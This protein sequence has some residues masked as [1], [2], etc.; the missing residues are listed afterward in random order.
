MTKDE[1]LNNLYE[2]VSRGNF[3]LTTKQ[4]NDIGLN[5]RDIK[6]LVGN[7]TLTF[8]K[9]GYYSFSNVDLLY[10]FGTQ[11][12]NNNNLELAKFFWE[13]C[14][15]L[16]KYF[17]SAYLRLLSIYISEKDYENSFKCLKKLDINKQYQSDNNFYWYLL[18]YITEVPDE[19]KEQIKNFDTGDIKTS[20][21]K[22]K[23]IDI[24][25]ENKIRAN[26]FSG[27]LPYALNQL[28]DYY[29]SKEKLYI[30][31]II[32]K[33]L[34][35]QAVD[36]TNI[37]YDEFIMF[38]SNKKYN[39]IYEQ[40]LNFGAQRN[41]ST[42][43]LCIIKLIEC[44]SGLLENKSYLKQTCFITESV[45][46]A[47]NNHNYK[48]AYELNEKH[49]LE[50]GE[51]LKAKLLSGLLKELI[52]LSN[53]FVTYQDDN[54]FVEKQYNFIK[55]QGV[56]LLDSM[57]DERI[58]NIIKVVK[59][60]PNLDCWVIND[61]YNNRLVLRYINN[62]EKINIK[63][64]METADEYYRLEEY[65]SCIPLYKKLLTVGEPPVKIYSR[66]GFAHWKLKKNKLASDYFI[67]ANHIAQEK[68]ID[69]DYI[70]II[71]RLTRYIVS[72]SSKP[73]F[74][75][76]ENIS[77]IYEEDENYGLGNID[78]IT[79]FILNSNTDVE[80][81]CKMLLMN[82]EQIDIL[83]L[84]YA[85]E[86]YYKGY[87]EKGNEFIEAVEMS[88]NKTKKVFEILELIKNNKHLYQSRTE[89]SV[90][91]LTLTLTPNKNYS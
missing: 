65:G 36:Q 35:V 86:F 43:E 18:S 80:S 45:Y 46:E 33:S 38:A 19:H 73:Y 24:N 48:L 82:Q 83:R 63:H 84:V 23:I 87:L 85:R 64:V 56:I 44:I 81:A 4:L 72:P 42:Y 31:D 41:L 57:T 61:G 2:L 37:M 25:I 26:I 62:Q 59:K 5:S 60:H 30:K 21:N 53:Q 16:D 3:D 66:L 28:N 91:N 11:M 76:M 12:V 50:R 32:V 27:N 52:V 13:K 51:S 6:N 1:K 34:L 71:K 39:K 54:I 75:E 7:K 90:L 67:I 77:E 88:S 20:Q 8:V 17:L 68:N 74:V 79:E 22:N 10:S 40:L 14:V 69:V 9:R 47:I 55:K 78:D 89:K 58:E 49:I 70:E 29:K 15:E